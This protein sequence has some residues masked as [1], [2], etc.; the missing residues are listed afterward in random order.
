VSNLHSEDW[1]DQ[2]SIVGAIVGWMRG[3]CVMSGNN[4]VAAGVEKMGMRTF[5]MTA[6]GFNLT[7]LMHSSIVDRAAESPIFADLTGG[8]AQVSDLR[9]QDAFRAGIMK[10][11]KLQAS[12]TLRERTREDAGIPFDEAV[13][14][15]QLKE[16]RAPLPALWTN[17][18]DASNLVPGRS[19]SSW[20]SCLRV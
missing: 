11:A 10:T 5:S 6:V 8:M 7:A 20:P 14:R 3:M 16:L 13:G 4:V 18:N 1:D 19:S 12:I 15:S 17:E 9:D 2:L